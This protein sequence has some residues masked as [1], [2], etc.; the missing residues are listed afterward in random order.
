V[1]MATAELQLDMCRA[2]NGTHIDVI[3]PKCDV[4]IG[5]SKVKVKLTLCF[6]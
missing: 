6:N 2:T 3:H 5:K 4:Y 1:R